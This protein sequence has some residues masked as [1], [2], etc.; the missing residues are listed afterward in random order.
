MSFPQKNLIIG[1]KANLHVPKEIWPNLFFNCE[2]LGIP[3]VILNGRVYPRDVP[4]YAWASW[5]FRRV[6]SS[7]HWIGVQNATERERFLRIGARPEQ[8]Q[9]AGNAKFDLTETQL[10]PSPAEKAPG[11]HR[12]LIV[13]GSSHWPEEK[14]LL[15]SLLRL[16]RVFPSLRL[17]LAPRHTRRVPSMERLVRGFGLT[18][19]KWSDLEPDAP[20]WDVLLVN[21]MGCLPDLYRHADVVVVGGSLVKRGGHNMLEAAAHGRAIVAGPH[22]FH[23]QEIVEELHRTGGIVWLKDHRDL[24]GALH[25]LLDDE[26]ARERMGQ[27]AYS[28]LQSRR[29]AATKYSE[30]LSQILKAAVHTPRETANTALEPPKAKALTRANSTECFREEPGT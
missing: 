15:A 16:R 7:V 26:K 4:R 22:V 6:L 23:F 21:E 10:H 19:L 3:L 8:L 11:L 2:K 14:W 18:P 24:N 12:P 25:R 20:H 30:T 17:I 5:F 29:G 28:F 27:E 9:V 13:A 1:P